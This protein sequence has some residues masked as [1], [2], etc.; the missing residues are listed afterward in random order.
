MVVPPSSELPALLD[1][2]QPWNPHSWS[3]LLCCRSPR[4]AN[5]R[6]NLYDAKQQSSFDRLVVC[7]TRA[8][9]LCDSL[10]NIHVHSRLQ[11]SSPRISLSSL[12]LQS[13]CIIE[14]RSMPATDGRENTTRVCRSSIVDVCNDSYLAFPPSSKVIHRPSCQALKTLDAFVDLERNSPY[15]RA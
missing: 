11:S 10:S 6:Y 3:S 5:S 7:D 15:L 4:R 1:F 9:R 2:L 13:S 12:G 14:R 8:L